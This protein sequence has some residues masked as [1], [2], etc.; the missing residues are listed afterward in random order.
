MISKFNFTPL[1]E[2]EQTKTAIQAFTSEIVHIQKS[3]YPAQSDHS[4]L[5][6]ELHTDGIRSKNLA[7]PQK[8]LESI[9]INLDLK[10]HKIV[11]T[12]SMG[13][14]QE[15]YLASI[16]STHHLNQIIQNSIQSFNL[17]I[18]IPQPFTQQSIPTSYLPHQA[19]P[20]FENI[21]SL[22]RFVQSWKHSTAY[23]F[24]S[25]NFWPIRMQTSIEAFGDR[26]VYF[27]NDEGTFESPAQISFGFS[28]A[29]PVI[30]EPYIFANPWPFKNEF[31]H[32]PLPSYARWYTE[33]WEG[34]LIQLSTLI[35][36]ITSQETLANF[37]NAVIQASASYL[38]T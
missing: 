24:S 4:H 21:S 3:L 16:K 26:T 12:N 19:T 23:P 18:Q 14:R 36:P 29:N 22:R 11:S 2:W 1:I 5:A 33:S 7:Y 31:T 27:K 13:S 30:K 28:T 37:F 35:N 20:Y 15:F 25:F 38:S 10:N 8:K 9:Q 32:R 34:S 17:P 6:L